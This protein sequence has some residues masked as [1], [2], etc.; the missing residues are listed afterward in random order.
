MAN[1]LGLKGIGGWHNSGACL[2]DSEKEEIFFASEEERF[3]NEKYT[4]M[5]PF[6]SLSYALDASGLKKEDIDY[7]A[8]PVSTFEMLDS[9]IMDFYMPLMEQ[10]PLFLLPLKYSLN[11][12][13]DLT[14]VELYLG[15]QFPNAK[16]LMLDHHDTHAAG[17]FFCSPFDEAA[18]FTIDGS[19]E[20]ATTTFGIGQG[21]RIK[22]IGQINFPN[23]LGI[24]YTKVSN[25][26]GFGG[27]NPEGKVMALA[28]FGEPAF[29]DIFRDAIKITDK[30]QF[31]ID[32]KYFLLD[33]F[34]GVELLP[35]FK[36]ILGKER[37]PNET[38]MKVHMDIAASLQ[39]RLEEVC[40][41]LVKGLYEDTKMKNICLS[42][43]VAL[44]SV[45]NKKILDQTPFEN[46]FIH[47]ASN[48]GG[49]PLGAALYVKHML[50]NGETR[51]TRW[52][53]AYLGA[54]Y[55]KEHVENLLK[56]R[57]IKYHVPGD[58]LKKVAGLLA[59]GKIVG[60]FQGKAEYGPRALGNRSILCDPRRGEMKDIL[61]QRVKHREWFR[62]F[63]PVV[64]AEK[65]RDY[66]DIG[67][68]S[69]YMLLVGGI[70]SSKRSDVEA[71]A[72][73][74]G[75]ARVQTVTKEQNLKLYN[76]LEEFMV[77]TG[78]PVLLNT[79]FNIGQESIVNSPEDALDCFLFTEIDCLVLEDVLIL[80][81]ENQ[82]KKIKISYEAYLQK[83]KQRYLDIFHD[84]IENHGKAM[85]LLN[86][87]YG[88]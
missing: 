70:H 71:T 6:G 24:V 52:D 88:R 67:C 14:K 61:N 10:N 36:N 75:S 17:A 25:F 19:G 76:L 13:R 55:S 2:I 50:F 46:I 39:L 85:S 28:S 54:E 64:I 1:V 53:N 78:V 7:V 79:S 43:G 58:L 3:N 31:L 51:N 42:G 62:P 12:Y 60:W 69:P 66:F 15:Q 80:K 26:L 73:V 16:I 63:A 57:G 56:D 20:M 22:R 45:M 84:D 65:S 30:Y 40:L 81:E 5:Y 47:P 32:G 37:S 74:D 83:R 72:H 29:I 35:E 33:Q 4:S 9:L 44:N 86:K 18:I 23:S 41:H 59:E 48:D 27:P 68:E 11:V 77:V 49:T 8:Y 38:L 21:G 34:G 82:D 87:M